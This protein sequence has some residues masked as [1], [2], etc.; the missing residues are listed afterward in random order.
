MYSGHAICFGKVN[1]GARFVFYC[2]FETFFCENCSENFDYDPLD[3]QPVLCS[4]NKK[5]LSW[6]H[7]HTI[8]CFIKSDFNDQ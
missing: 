3:F 7:T 4:V 1:K 2:S 8:G 5:V 6:Q